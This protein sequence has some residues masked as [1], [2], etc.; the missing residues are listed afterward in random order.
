MA[1][2]SRDK[3]LRIEREVVNR[4]KD[5]GVVARRVP[6]S[7]AAEGY[8]G[9]VIIAD[10][11]TGEVKARKAGFKSIIDWLGDNDILFLRPD[12]DTPYVFMP[13]ETYIQLIALWGKQVDQ[14]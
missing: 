11:F 7:G 9:D 3:G 5:I 13:W 10:H 8:P 4:H 14:P 12:G 1:K 6:L 2:K